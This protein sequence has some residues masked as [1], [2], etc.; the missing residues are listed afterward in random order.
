[1]FDLQARD[2]VLTELTKNWVVEAGAGTGKTTLLILRLCEAVLVQNV[3]VEKIVAL[4]FT[5]KAA[6]EIKTRFIIQLHQIIEELTCNEPPASA[7]TNKTRWK[8]LL[9]EHFQLKK[10][11]IIAR[12]E[13]ALARLD[14]SNMGTIHSF[15]ADI[16]KTFPLE[17][18]LAPHAEIDSGQ[19]GN[20]LFE[21]RW[22]AFLDIELGV[23]APRESLWKRVLAQ[24]SLP[25]LKVFAQTLCSGKITQYN[26]FSHAA[27]LA[28]LCEEK[29][30][31]AKDW[32][33]AFLPPGKK[34]RNTEKALDW[35]SQSLL[36]CA[37]F[38]R[39]KKI[40]D[41]LEQ[42]PPAFPASVSQG[43]DESYFEQAR[44]LVAFA[45][46]MIPENQQIFLDAFALISPVVEQVRQDYRQEGILSFDDLLV[47]TRDLLQRDLY[48]RR[49]LK[50]KFDIL[51]IDEFQDTDPVQG[52]LLLFLAEEKL[53]SASRW[54]EVRLEPGKLFVVGD[55]KQSIYR[56]R[57]A[58]I[59]AYELF[60]E[61]I[62]RQGGEKCFLQNNFRSSPGIV[63]VAN[64]V[65]RRAMI[66]Q[67]SFQP[68]YVP[69]IAEKSSKACAVEWLFIRPAEQDFQADDYR[70]NQGEQ[71]ARWIENNVGQLSLENGYKLTYGDIAIL[72]RASTTL[73]PY[74]EALRRYGI[75]FNV[76]TD[77]DFYRKQEI[78]DFL[79][80]LRVIAEPEN[81]IALVGVLRSPWGGFTDEEIY[82]IVQRDELSLNAKTADSRLATCYSSLRKFVDK[83][84]R[85]PLKEILLSVLEETFLPEACAVAYDGQET[86][87][88]L[89][90]LIRLVET[91]Q[92]PVSLGQFLASVQELL[93]QEPERLGAS[94]VEAGENAVS[95]MTIHK[96]KGL[97]F[98]VVILADLS[99]KETISSGGGD[100]VFSWQYNMHGVR[101]GKI[102]DA[103]LAFLEGEQKKHERCEEIRV[104]YVALTRAREKMI[105]VSDGRKGAEK[106]LASFEN[107]G[108]LPTGQEEQLIVDEACVPVNSVACFPVESF[109]YRSAVRKAIPFS[110]GGLLPWKQAFEQRLKRYEQAK[111]D[112]LLSPSERVES[113]QGFTPAQRAGAALGTVC[114]RAL[115]Y[116]L[117]QPGLS[118]K[119]AIEKASYGVEIPQEPL[120]QL[121]GAFTQSAIWT[122]IKKNNVLAVEMPFT[123]TQQQR[124]VSGTMDVV[125]EQTDGSIWVI[126]YKTDVVGPLGIRA[127]VEKYRPQLEVYKQAAQQIFPNKTVRMSAVF[128]R[129]FASQDL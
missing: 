34:P 54:Q 63:T 121:L 90:R 109:R 65:C 31:Q 26:Y 45:Q 52:E 30:K 75:A 124:T 110:S 7:P 72:V 17:A 127:L 58:D 27:M 60:T 25:D 33:R 98:P 96:S 4:T 20:A 114:H 15:C 107:A 128:V 78:N 123:V 1:M 46:K 116:L 99:R 73:G 102:C 42:T 77:K 80:F 97:E 57:G 112:V 8:Y 104:L 24:I 19:R 50:E 70:H 82:Q 118:V 16:L 89:Q 9:T 29:S 68:A 71:I 106:A 91:Y 36:R 84:G 69:I 88:N 56:F 126:D 5:E 51:F 35:A 23:S 55:P 40:P 18:G 3:P 64:A 32:S 125:L 2:K 108:L 129:A 66:Q 120:L 53:S 12:G 86:L 11:D 61:L 22:N 81:R 113:G 117:T 59:T 85:V 74:T 41:A 43:W 95:V 49:L 10:E 28:A 122:E 111:K 93:A 14:R 115:E 76:E 37:A 103:N 6:A 83:V 13:M 87:A 101:A 62:L 21:A 79:N 48:V 92:T 44:D 38:L 67:A 94:T 39:T 119:Q 105:L 100:H 47:K